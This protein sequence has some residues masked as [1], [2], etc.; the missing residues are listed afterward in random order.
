MRERER[1]KGRERRGRAT[2]PTASAPHAD[3]KRARAFARPLSRQERDRARKAFRS[4]AEA[5]RFFKGAT[6][7]CQTDREK[8]TARAARGQ[9]S[10]IGDD[11]DNLVSSPSLERGK[12][13]GLG[14]QRRRGNATGWTDEGT[15]SSLS[16]GIDA[17]LTNA[18]LTFRGGEI[19]TR[20]HRRSASTSTP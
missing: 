9:P 2:A 11:A 7:S 4:L 18:A 20:R 3:T 17:L 12:R 10:I 8:Q 14:L 19:L 6:F 1:E 15:S 5:I 13:A 16:F